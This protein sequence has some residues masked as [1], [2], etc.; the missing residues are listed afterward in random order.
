MQT[1]IEFFLHA[2]IVHDSPRQVSTA[3][4]HSQHQRRDDSCPQTGGPLPPLPL[5]THHVSPEY[6]PGRGVELV[7]VPVVSWQGG[8]DG[9]LTHPHVSQLPGQADK[10][11]V[12]CPSSGSQREKL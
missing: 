6:S 7:P 3:P 4:S 9:H 1:N 8:I 10:M 2:S 11:F 5:H 12:R